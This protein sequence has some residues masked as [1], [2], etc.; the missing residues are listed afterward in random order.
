VKGPQIMF[1]T[2]FLQHHTMCG[3]PQNAKKVFELLVCFGK[4]KG[5]HT[6][7]E[8]SSNDVFMLFIYHVQSVANTLEH[9]SPSCH[10]IGLKRLHLDFVGDG[11]LH[12]V[13]LGNRLQRKGSAANCAVVV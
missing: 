6:L 1:I 8:W 5:I 7:C 3:H 11:P 2:V 10:T 12:K 9:L 13:Y 4:K